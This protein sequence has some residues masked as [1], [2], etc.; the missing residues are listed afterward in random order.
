MFDTIGIW[1]SS[2]LSFFSGRVLPTVI[3]LVAGILAIRVAMKLAQSA[4][5]KTKLDKSLAKLALA[6][7]QPVLYLLLGLM[8]ADKLG[9]DVTGV[10]ALA[11]V[12]TLAV[13]LSLQSALGNVFG[14]F[15]LIY[16]KPFAPGDYVEI[17]GREG[18]VLE[19]GIAYTKLATPDNKIISLPN[20]SVVAT[21]I[22]NYTISGKR[23]VD[24]VVRCGWNVPAQQVMDA[25]LE[26]AKLDAVFI[27]PAP[28]VALTT[29]ADGQAEYKLMVWCATG[30]YFPVCF[31]INKNV[32]DIFTRQNIPMAN[33]RMTVISEK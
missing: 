16:T 1:L 33:P 30:D 9:I 17:A 22:V 23:R 11:S 7:L 4:L 27:D 21:E 25:L 20:S 28:A 10:V 5:E 12:L 3:I 6:V 2:L 19:T 26:A 13:S 24:V 32:Q 14:G 15:S 29:Y 8:A 31:A 18:T